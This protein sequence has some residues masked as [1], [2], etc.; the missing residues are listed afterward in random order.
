MRARTRACAYVRVW[1]RVWVCVCVCV[2]VCVC[3][4]VCVWMRVWIILVDTFVLSEY[5]DQ[6]MQEQQM[7]GLGP[8]SPVHMGIRPPTMDPY[9]SHLQH[10]GGYAMHSSVAPASPPHSMM[11][12]SPQYPGAFR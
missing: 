10:M 11:M 1:V 12:G 9:R 7:Q 6:Q 2:R 8:P 3:V 5:P 4:C